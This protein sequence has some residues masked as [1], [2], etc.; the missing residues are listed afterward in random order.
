MQLEI[1]V[2]IIG[3]VATII[4]ALV[5]VYSKSKKGDDAESAV[6][7][8]D[9][10]KSPALPSLAERA[11]F[12]DT[13]SDTVFI[14]FG[15]EY[16]EDKV[17][18]GHPEL[19]LRDLK[20]AAIILAFLSRVYPEKRVEFIPST[21][22]GWQEPLPED[23][24]LIIIGGFV[25]NEEFA[26]HRSI[27]QKTF[28]LK[29]GRLC[30]F[31][32]RRV[33]HVE[34]T[35]L[36]KDTVRS[37]RREP[38]AIEDLPSKYISGDFALVCNARGYIYG[39]ERRVIA[40]AGIKGNGTLGAAIHLTRCERDSSQLNTIL[41]IPL[42][43][44]KNDTLG[45]V[46][47][48]GIVNDIVNETKI[49]EAVLNG[50]SILD[51]SSGLW[52]LCELDQSCEDCAFGEEIPSIS[53]IQI[54]AVIFDLDDTL[55]DTFSM[56]ITPLEDEAAKRM[57]QVNR[58]LP[59]SD[60]LAALLLK[61]RRSNP[62]EIEKEL[63]RQIPDVADGA[64]EARQ[65]VFTDLVPYRLSIDP[66]VRLLLRELSSNYDLYL[67]TEGDSDFQNAKIDHLGIRSFFNEVVTASP[68]P[69]SKRRAI[70]S[71]LERHH[72]IPSSVLIIG[73]RLDK[74]IYAGNK[75]GMTTVWIERGE[76]GAMRPGKH[77]GLPVPNYTVKDVLELRKVLDQLCQ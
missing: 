43:N 23:V 58:S 9:E 11:E 34:L 22:T 19:S 26:W 76:G 14:V 68:G 29:M 69:E 1:I 61:L 42:S 57:V 74:E 33:Y 37:L 6:R 36:S 8:S 52:K 71:L 48:T 15:A 27:Y 12:W 20:A 65:K 64:L 10:V 2:A 7:A 3:G 46:I 60:E 54:N 70:A 72:Y 56:L 39:S 18:N 67:L 32:K 4:A 53:R 16:A 41:K 24:N 5:G 47:Q 38:Q 45:L 40:I 17:V 63:L 77:T 55:V 73:N 66:E 44:K 25:A 75:L 31:K 35:D 62:A 28:R 51:N 59:D 30:R 50:K 13:L 21:T 49:V